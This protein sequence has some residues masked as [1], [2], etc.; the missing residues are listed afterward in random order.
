MAKSYTEGIDNTA[1][2]TR[3]KPHST[4]GHFAFAPATQQTTVVTTTTTTVNLAPFIL[5]PPPSLHNRDPKQ[6]PL[7]TSRTPAH[8]RSFN[9]KL[10]GQI[11]SYEEPN[12]AEEFYERFYQQQR[13]LRDA[14]GSLVELEEAAKSTEQ[15]WN[16]ENAAPVE[17]AESRRR[18]EKRVSR[19]STPVEQTGMDN[20]GSEAQNPAPHLDMHDMSPCNSDSEQRHPRKLQAS[21]S[22]HGLDDT[23]ITPELQTS[24]ASRS[25]SHQRAALTGRRGARSDGHQTRPSGGSL[26]AA[27]PPIMDSDVEADAPLAAPPVAS[28]L[29][30]LLTSSSQQDASLPSPS[31]SPVTAAANMA[32]RHLFNRRQV[33]NDDVSDLSGLETDHNLRRRKLPPLFNDNSV[34]SVKDAGSSTNVHNFESSRTLMDVPDMVLMFDSLPEELQSYVMFQL[35]KRSSKRTLR[36]VAEVVNPALKCDP[37]DILPVELSLKITKFLDGESLCQAA[38]VSKRWRHLINSDETAWKE[39]LD[40]EGYTLPD[41]EIERAIREG[42][43]WQ[44]AGPN[45]YEKDLSLKKTSRPS[46]KFEGDLQQTGKGG[47]SDEETSSATRNTRK[48]KASGMTGPGSAKRQKQKASAAQD[49]ELRWMRDLQKGQG[50]IAYASAAARAL[51]D[52][53]VGLPSLKSLHLFKSIYRRHRLMKETWMTGV[54]Q[55]HHLAF[56]AHHRHVVTCLLFDSERIITGSDDT[57][58]NVFDTK[59]GVLRRRLEGH[60]GGVWALSCEGDILVSGSTDRSVRVWDIKTGRCIQTFQGHTSTVRCLVI[61][62]P[63]ETGKDEDGNPIMHPNEPIIIT[64]SRDSTLRVWRLPKLSDPSMR[65]PRLDETDADNDYAL[66]TLTGHHN[67]VRAIAAHGDTLVSGSYDFTVRVWRISNGEMVHRLQGHTAKVYS[68]VLDHERGRCISGSMDTMVRV[69]SLE[70]GVCLMNLEGH[71][72]LVGLL[73]LNHGHLVS[74]AADSTLRVWDPESG[75]CRSALCAHTGAITCFQHDGQKVISGSDRTLKMWN[76][77]TG[78]CARDLLTD[79]SGVWQVRFDER[80]C[81]AAVQRN[82]LTYIEVLDFG[83]SRDGI[84]AKDRGRRIVVDSRGREIHEDENTTNAPVV[85]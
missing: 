74:A 37:F 2:G 64:G 4:V 81:V 21:A 50:P 84:P 82:S 55:P 73:E 25:S 5:Q 69:W 49:D 57:S 6:F 56:R 34:L 77:Q 36:T 60:E 16:R 78:E 19:I 24:A 63:V 71:N 27:T 52:P 32:Q 45:N 44:F 75:A 23:I 7:V 35:L 68:V 65:R 31:L 9:F 41:G 40:R 18:K 83:A 76:I 1:S 28:A 79:L 15:V 12:D 8:L 29:P 58:I 11:T 48:R 62:K 20:G 47:L 46:G 26:A 61:L 22:N 10:G 66:R 67:S 85:I 54:C 80:R 42:W 14:G 30:P 3:M 38:S 51:P 17:L 70:T 39:L 53:K 33:D 59:T 43:G 72:S 13:A